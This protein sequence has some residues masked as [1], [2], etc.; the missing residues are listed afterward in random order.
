MRVVAFNG[1]ARKG[2][3]TAIML[4]TVLAELTAEGIQT[5]L[6]ELA[7]VRLTG[8]EA[9]YTCRQRKDRRCVVPGDPLN[10]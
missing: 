5:E 1:S 10:D 6:I 8:C 7:G 9:C 4:Q 3:N 2:G